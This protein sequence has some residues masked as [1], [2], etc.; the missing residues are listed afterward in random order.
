MQFIS[1]EW[2]DLDDAI[3]KTSHTYK[4]WFHKPV[5]EIQTFFGNGTVWFDEA[6]GER[7]PTHIE[8]KL[9]NMWAKQ[10]WDRKYPPMKEQK[11]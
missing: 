2:Q 10:K 4:R 3:I 11:Q 5:T 8:A 1:I 6:T 7:Q 9:Y